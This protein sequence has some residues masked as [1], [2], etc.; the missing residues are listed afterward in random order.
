MALEGKQLG[1]Y[2]LVR[3]VGVG[4]MGEIYLANDTRI[5]RQVALK[6]LRTA[7]E[8]DIPWQQEQE[9]AR[10]FLGEA[11]AIATL[12]HP[13]I[14]PLFDYG[15]E[16]L[17][18]RNIAFLVMP[19]RNEGTLKDWLRRKQPGSPIS[20]YD[21]AG[22][23][24][25]AA[26][27]LQYAH[28]RRIIHQDIKPSN[29]LIRS[30]PDRP[31][32]PDIMLADFGIAKLSSVTTQLAT[33]NPRGTPAYMAPEQWEGKAYPATDQYALAM[34]AY[35]ML[36]GRTPFHGS[37]NQLMYAHLQTQPPPPSTYNQRLSPDID[38]VV[39]KALSKQPEERFPSIAAFATALQQAAATGEKTTLNIYH[40]T[41]E[42]PSGILYNN[43]ATAHTSASTMTPRELTTG[44]PTQRSTGG[45][46]P[47]MGPSNAWQHGSG[48]LQPGPATP[49]VPEQNRTLPPQKPLSGI[50]MRMAVLI[51]LTV[52]VV[53]AGGI[54]GILYFAHQNQGGGEQVNK[55]PT[56]TQ[57][58][59]TQAAPTPTPTIDPV[60][61]PNNP[62]PP[63][64]GT[65]VMDDPLKDNTSGHS[66]TLENTPLLSSCYFQ[67]QTYHA[68]DSLGTL[69]NC[70]SQL[71]LDNGAF[72]VQVKLLKGESAGLLLRGSNDSK[73]FYFFYIK[74]D[75][76]YGL[77]IC[78][79]N[80]GH[81]D[82]SIKVGGSKAIH[83]KLGETNLLAI[84]AQGDTLDLYINQQHITTVKD[85]HASKGFVGVA[86]YSTSLAAT[87]AAFS[88]ARAWRF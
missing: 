51:T 65:L 81:P 54:G 71:E 44:N 78:T 34:M 4:G 38:Y 35:E 88:N 85:T 76:S 22:F 84:V 36:A 11:Q 20:P 59:A 86:S 56:T 77:A 68:A 7:E 41:N 50:N 23:I 31:R 47:P 66:W 37:L 25:Q 10:L 3:R 8:T 29:F 19:F 60:T 73:G 64:K 2:Q 26:G 43:T 15:E 6:V 5:T 33:S 24:T 57:A 12:D 1:R 87:D 58:T 30:N 18:G 82:T 75:G 14:L 48:T 63:N 83:T 52:L 40:P 53:L 17:D 32:R 72:Q 28:N 21:V 13:F 9:A 55:T 67:N 62:Y 39:L 74:T 80:G 61:S 45:N 16:Q 27:A 49:P 46:I 79:A 70:F 69:S 42:F